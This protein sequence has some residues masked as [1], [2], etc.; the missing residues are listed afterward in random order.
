MI[1]RFAQHSPGCLGRRYVFVGWTLVQRLR[2]LEMLVFVFLAAADQ[3]VVA[4][5]PALC[6]ECLP[7]AGPMVVGRLSH[8]AVLADRGPQ[9]RLELEARRLVDSEGDLFPYWLI[10]GG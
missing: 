3:V 2:C 8:L 7:L 5:V 4:L 10:S 1:G 6:P 9:V